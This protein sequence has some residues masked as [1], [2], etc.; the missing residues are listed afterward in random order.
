MSPVS[1]NDSRAPAPG[2][3]PA[4]AS[5]SWVVL[6]LVAGL[7]LGVF[8][9]RFWLADR[10][11]ARYDQLKAQFDQ[12]SMQSQ[13]DT[14]HLRAR[15][16]ALQGQLDIEA[17][18]RKGLEASLATVQGQ[19]GRARDQLAFF[20]QLF[21]PGPSGSVSIRALEVRQQGALLAYK[22]LLS[23]NAAPDSLFKGSLRF[24]AQGREKDKTV[25]IT[26]MPAR[27]GSPA[28]Q[29]G[30]D[31][32]ALSFD[33]FQ[34]S[35][36]KLALPAGFTPQSVTLSVLEGDTVRVTRTVKPSH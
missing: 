5:W 2:R 19:L 17:G 29:G 11:L 14:D 9:A 32:L 12:L 20:Q 28:A 15:L 3:K 25:K 8:A 35:E 34:R 4:R 23:R 22:I 27:A 30:A 7:A 10:G 13:A 26:L 33:Q 24:V 36:G 1:R 21:P 16:D 6:A 31:E 18:T